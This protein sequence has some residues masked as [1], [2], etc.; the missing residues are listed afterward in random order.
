M[1][2]KGYTIL[3]LPPFKRILPLPVRRIRG[4]RTV[5]VTSCHKAV[6]CGGMM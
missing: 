5:M 3:I 6:C 4:G 1:L 2:F